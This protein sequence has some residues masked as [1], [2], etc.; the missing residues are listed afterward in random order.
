[1]RKEKKI[2]KLRQVKLHRKIKRTG[3]QR[4]EKIPKRPLQVS[5]TSQLEYIGERRETQKISG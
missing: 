4:N 2:K 5:Q 3:T 1:M